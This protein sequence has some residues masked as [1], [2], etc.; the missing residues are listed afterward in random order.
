[1]ICLYGYSHFIS[2]IAVLI[3]SINIPLLHYI[4]LGYAL[5]SRLLFIIGNV[6]KLHVSPSKKTL[7]AGL[8]IGEAVLMFLIFKFLLINSY[9]GHSFNY[10]VCFSFV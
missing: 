10:Q 4:V 5:A 7:V 3:C 6:S 2:I 8:I 1:M 9:I